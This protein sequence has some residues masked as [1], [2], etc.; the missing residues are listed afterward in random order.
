MN[1]EFINFNNLKEILIMIILIRMIRGLFMIW[2]PSE[3]DC[4]SAGNPGFHF[5]YRFNQFDS[6]VRL[7]STI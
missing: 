7:S 4:P 3:T 6:I 2:L 5:I 1:V